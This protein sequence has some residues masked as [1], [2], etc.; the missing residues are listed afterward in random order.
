[1]RLEAARQL[2]RDGMETPRNGEPH[3]LEE[4]PRELED[5][6]C[7]GRSRAGRDG[8]IEHVPALLKRRIDAV[9]PLQALD[10][11]RRS[12]APA[13]PGYARELQLLDREAEAELLQQR[14]TLQLVPPPEG[15]PAARGREIPVLVDLCLDLTDSRSA[16]ERSP[17]VQEVAG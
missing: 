12:V 4:A 17:V 11:K 16:S 5:E 3:P 7:S 15:E 2:H 8:D 1:S 10:R 13:R 14:G 9:H 6:V